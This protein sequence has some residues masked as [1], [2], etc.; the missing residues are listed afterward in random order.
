MSRLLS[1]GKNHCP[2]VGAYAILFPGVKKKVEALRIALAQIVSLPGRGEDNARKLEVF[3]RRAAEGGAALVLFPE[4][5]LTGYA[6]ESAARDALSPDGPLVRSVEEASLRTG[7]AVC[8]GYAERGEPLPFIT[9]EL[10]SGG[11]RILYRKTH[12]GIREREHFRPGDEFPLLRAAGAAWGMQ[13][14]WES[15]IPDISTVLRRRG[16]EALLVP[17]AAG[18]GGGRCRE[19]W[20]VH[21]PARASDNGV[22]LAACNALRRE[23]GGALAGGGGM[24]IDPR[25]RIAAE[26]FEPEEHVLFCDISGPLPREQDGG[27]GRISYFDRRREELYGFDA[28]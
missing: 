27:M 1:R 19:N 18:P 10:F 9:Q 5:S 8:F 3:L 21:L 23:S 14:C 16:A 15:H 26:F 22:W 25:G 24:V 17:Y 20:L 4:C 6:P 12:T 13:L 2:G 7:V 28:E 11:E